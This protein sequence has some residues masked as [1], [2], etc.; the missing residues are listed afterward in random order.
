MT[1][2]Q[3]RLREIALIP[4]EEIDTQRHLRARC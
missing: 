4:D 3:A 2:S 1:I